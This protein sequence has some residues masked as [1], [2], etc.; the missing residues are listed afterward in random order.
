MGGCKLTSR[1]LSRSYLTSRRMGGSKLTLRDLSRSGPESEYPKPGKLHSFN[2]MSFTYIYIYIQA[3]DIIGKKL[4][5]LYL[6][7]LNSQYRAT[8]LPSVHE[9]AKF[10]SLWT[11]YT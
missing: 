4:L 8:F 9:I 10:I 7:R 3:I 6:L 1:M 2:Q 5:Y 11:P